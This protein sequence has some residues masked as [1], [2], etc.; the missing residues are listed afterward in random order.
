M[1]EWSMKKKGKKPEN[2]MFKT[3]GNNI[4]FRNKSILTVYLYTEIDQCII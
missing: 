1:N 2:Q 4:T 3:I